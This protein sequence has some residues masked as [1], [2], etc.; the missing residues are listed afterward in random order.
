MTSRFWLPDGLGGLELLRADASHHRYSRHSH[1]GYAL[2]VVE[3]GAHAFASRGRVWTATPGSVV[4]VNPDDA[5]D[6]GPAR[7][8]GEYWYRMLY[9][10]SSVLQLA[11]ASGEDRP[12]ATPFFPEAVVR[13]PELAASLSKLHRA[14]ERPEALLERD[15]LLVTSLVYLARR[16]GRTGVG[17]STLPPAAPKAVTLA[18]EFISA[19][20]TENFSL[21]RLAALA[22]VS[23]FHL[24]RAFRHS[25]GLPPHLYQTQLRL[26]HARRLL[27]SGHPPTRAAAAAGFADQSHLIRKF[28][29]AYGITPGQFLGRRNNVQSATGGVR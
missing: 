10:D 1:E 14:L 4:I 11:L 3:G 12:A 23:R 16:H 17:H 24:L 22:G 6:G 21:A 9:V 2:G 13:D 5:H 28:K 8:D 19:N 18:F 25:V 27:A 29:A 20:F 7:R 26:R 15:T